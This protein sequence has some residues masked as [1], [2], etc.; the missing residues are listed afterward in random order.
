MVQM[1]YVPSLTDVQVGDVV[2]TAG[3]DGIFPKGIPIGQVTKVEEGKD[4]FK[5]IWIRPSVD[6]TQLEEV[7]VIHTKKIP[8][9]VVRYAP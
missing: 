3:I 7:M 1:F 4:L 2:A 6:F 5:Q 9:A 8:D